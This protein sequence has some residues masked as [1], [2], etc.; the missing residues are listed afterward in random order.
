MENNIKLVEELKSGNSS[1]TTFF[2]N[3]VIKQL[4]KF[5]KDTNEETVDYYFNLAIDSYDESVKIPFVF[6]IGA[7]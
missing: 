2:K 5:N 7:V 6:H 3:E 4:K 1:R